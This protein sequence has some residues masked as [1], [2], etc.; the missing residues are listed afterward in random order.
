[1]ALFDFL[2]TIGDYVF[3]VARQKTKPT[4]V[5]SQNGAGEQG[6]MLVEQTVLPFGLFS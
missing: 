4:P 1:M 3:R 5:E 6:E 2:R